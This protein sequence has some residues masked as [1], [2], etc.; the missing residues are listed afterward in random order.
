MTVTTTSGE[1]TYTGTFSTDTDNV[2]VKA[3]PS[4]GSFTIE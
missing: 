4:I 2:V 3:L 1:G